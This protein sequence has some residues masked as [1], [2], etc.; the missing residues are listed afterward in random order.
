MP[1]WL[2]KMAMSIF[3]KP[4][5][6]RVQF[7]TPTSLTLSGGT[8]NNNAL[9]ATGSNAQATGNG[10]VALGI[11]STASGDY[12]MA[13]GNNTTASGN[14]A[15]AL[16]NNTTAQEYIQFVIG[17]YNVPQGTSDTFNNSDQIF[18]IGNGDDATHASDA[19]VVQKN[20]NIG[21]GTTTPNYKLDVSGDI[22]FTGTLYQSGT[23][24]SGGGGSRSNT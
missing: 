8:V 22:N 18:V 15:M 12:S 4:L 10:A 5:P 6:E 1:S 2:I 16:G 13:L 20:G 21:I 11:S 19:F 9:V 17:Q 23:A 24:F 3:P 14:Y 7:L